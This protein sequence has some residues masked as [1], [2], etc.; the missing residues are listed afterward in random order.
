MNLIQDIISYELKSG[1]ILAK[2]LLVN[3]K[4]LLKKDT[5]LTDSLIYKINQSYPLTFISIY[6]NSNPQNIPFLHEKNSIEYQ[7]I[8]DNFTYYS[9]IANNILNEIKYS[10]KINMTDVR[11][12]CENILHQLKEKGLVIKNIVEERTADEYLSRH[13]INVAVISTLI[14]TWLNISQKELNLLT[15]SAL[16]HDIGK[17]K[18]DPK[19]LNKATPL[20]EDEINLCRTHSVKGYEIAKK[21]PYIDQSVIFGI[22]FHHERSDGSGYPLKLKNSQIPLFAKIISIADIFD[23]MTSNRVYKQKE[24]P[25]NVLAEIKSA[26]FG[27]L[28]VE[29]G[30]IFVNNILQYYVGELVILNNHKIGKIIKIDIN[31]ITTPWIS[32]DGE[33]I[34]LFERKDL[35]IVDIL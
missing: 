29:I 31:N 4:V 26:I 1:M 9:N 13:S 34:D 27:K 10:D 25:L 30:T 33:V 3:N 6:A 18:I 17:V 16:L 8:N 24:C 11:N 19:I 14:G 5:E 21:I 15:Y 32:L 28:D 23:A 2:D 22:L 35:M 7:K 12:I 20:S